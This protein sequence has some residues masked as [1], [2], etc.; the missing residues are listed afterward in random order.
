MAQKSL[1]EIQK[2]AIFSPCRTWRYLLHRIWD[3]SKPYCGF[4]GLNPSTADETLDD[5]T[6]RRC[7]GFSQ[8]WG[9]GGYLMFNVF[10]FRATDPRDMER[11]PAPIGPDNDQTIFDHARRCGRL[12]AAWGNH[13]L[14]TS[15]GEWLCKMLGREIMCL[16]LNKF[17]TPKHPLY[18]RADVEPIIYYR[19]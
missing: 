7:I 4:I 1:F 8:D 19:P 14:A 12:V 10:G 15:R 16:E 18:V 2:G 13:K 9:Y 11:A 6:I 17:G 5:P 3:E